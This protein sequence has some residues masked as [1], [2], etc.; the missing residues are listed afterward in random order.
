MLVIPSEFAPEWI[1]HGQIERWVHEL[2]V[3]NSPSKRRAVVESQWP[4]SAVL[5]SALNFSA[6]DRGT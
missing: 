2:I 1:T 3:I 4:D 5:I 6:G